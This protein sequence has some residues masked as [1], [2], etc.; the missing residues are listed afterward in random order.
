MDTLVIAG[1]DSVVGAN[2]AG[3]L[4]DRF[5]VVGVARELA[6]RIAGCG[7]V[8]VSPEP[9]RQLFAAEQPQHVLYCGAAA[10]SSWTEEA[11]DFDAS[12]E[13]KVVR[14]WAKVATE[15]G[16]KLTYVSSDAVFAGPW[17]FHGEE[18]D[19][20]SSHP[21]AKALRRIEADVAKLSD[22]ALIV[23][24]HAFGWSPVTGQGAVQQ[25]LGQIE[26]TG[27]LNVDYRRHASP[28][29]AS[30]LAEFLDLAWQADADGVL[31]LSGAERVNPAAFAR[32]LAGHLELKLPFI[33]EN[34]A[35]PGEF[36]AGETALRN[37]TARKL[38]GIGMPMLFEGLNELCE[39][40]HNGYCEQLDAEAPVVA[41]VA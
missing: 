7:D 29:L 8:S 26:K 11:S 14:Q 27:E 1:V 28:I 31:H 23:R 12:E 36:G 5:R 41:N 34:E 35:A 17:M 9:P 16:A 21:S 32:Q 20:L 15:F 38:L 19:C 13:Q 37:A 25:M 39:Q 2:V 40:T 33:P 30:R 18:C 22:N 4:Y 6:V 3:T 24:T 10:R